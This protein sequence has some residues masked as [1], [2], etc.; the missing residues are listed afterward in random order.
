M[1]DEK[2]GNRSFPLCADGMVDAVH[3]VA[4]WLL[5]LKTA[6][7]QAATSSITDQFQVS[8][9]RPY[10]F[11]FAVLIHL[12]L[13]FPSNTYNTKTIFIMKKDGINRMKM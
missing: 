13:K 10:C 4:A 2:G 7:V 11:L 8:G 3:A 1:K 12:Y 5:F 9:E 6:L